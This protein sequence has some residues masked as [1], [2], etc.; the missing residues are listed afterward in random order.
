MA[1]EQEV[2]RHWWMLASATCGI[3]EEIE[4]DPERD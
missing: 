1:V 4:S 3:V 2:L